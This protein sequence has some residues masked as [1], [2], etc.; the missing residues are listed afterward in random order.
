MEVNRTNY[1][2][3][4]VL[5]WRLHALYCYLNLCMMQCNA[6]AASVKMIL[7]TYKPLVQSFLPGACPW[8]GRMATP[9]LAG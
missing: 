3:N 7:G 5:M 8:W 6:H 4:L 9:R 2:Q 1:L